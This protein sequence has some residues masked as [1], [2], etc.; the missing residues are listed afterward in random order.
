VNNAAKVDSPFKLVVGL[1]AVVVILAGLKASADFIS[2]IL[3]AIFF[4]ILITP[5]YFWLQRRGLPAWV[6]MLLVLAGIVTGAIAL[7]LFFSSAV[8]QLLAQLS[9]YQ[10]AATANLAELQSNWPAL[11]SG[12]TAAAV[13][14]GASQLMRSMLL[15]VLG[16]VSTMIVILVVMIFSILEARPLHRRLEASLGEGSPLLQQATGFARSMVRYFAIRTRINLFTGFLVVL[17]L[18][19]LRID[20]ALLWGVLTFFLSYVPYVGIILA[21]APSVAIAFAQG[22]VFK[23]VLVILGVSVINLSAENVIARTLLGRGLSVSPVIVFVSFI[24]WASILGA[25]G[26]LLAMPL[27]IVVMLVLAAF[28]STRWLAV[29][30]G[31]PAQGFELSADAPEETKLSTDTGTTA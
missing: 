5:I 28:D 23:A 21:T 29:L 13:A 18:L 22:G 9:T 12:E 31:M 14:D 19:L 3:L 30:M 20:F 17:L 16:L 27:T 10:D 26:T 2:P 24:F 7:A 6:A 15:G 8:N 11:G 1:A 25:S 4:A